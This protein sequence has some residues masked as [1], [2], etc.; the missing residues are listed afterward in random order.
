MAWVGCLLTVASFCLLSSSVYVLNDVLDREED[1]R[2]PT[3]R[4]RPIP[5]GRLSLQAAVVGAVV[6]VVTGLSVAAAVSVLLPHTR[7]LG[8]MGVLI[9]AGLYLLLNLAYSMWLKHK[10]VIDVLL[11]AFGFVLRAMAGASAIAAPISP[12]LV[13][14]TL[15]LCLFIALTKRRGELLSLESEQAGAVRPANRGYSLESLEHM[16]TV[17]TAMALITYSLYCVSPRTIHQFG[18]AHMIWTIPLVIYGTFRFNGV[19]RSHPGEDPSRVVLTDRVLWLV[20]AAYVVLVLL[21]ITVGRR[22]G[23][24]SVLDV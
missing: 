1:R 21:V 13:L 9:W 23:V 22:P 7:A 18:S 16:L 20:L 5:S 12:W 10:A 3:K 4:Y 6:L 24:R 15:T 14:C 2:H 17:S 8:G 11:V 19:T